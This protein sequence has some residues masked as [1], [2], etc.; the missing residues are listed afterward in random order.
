[1]HPR[2]TVVIPVFNGMPFLPEAVESILFQTYQDFLLL[3]IDDGSTDDSL[4]YLNSL[5]DPRIEIRQQRNLGLCHSLNG[6]IAVIKS[7]FVA[8][9]DQDDVALPS[10]LEEQMAFLVE[11]PNYTCVLSNISRIDANSREFGYYQNSSLGSVKDYHPKDYGSI[12]HSTICFRKDKFL[13]IGGYRQSVYPVDDFDLLLRF[14][15]KEKVA[16][17]DKPLVKYRIHSKAA[18]FK[19]FQD[20][21]MI[22]RYVTAMSQLRL[23]GKPEISLD[24]FRNTLDKSTLQQKLVRY[25]KQTGMLLFR[26]AGLLIGNGQ[27]I[28][29]I[30]SLLGAFLCNPQFVSKRL[31]TLRKG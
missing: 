16:V 9:L 6:A 13:E 29:G 14:W 18:T 3:I 2:L 31:L 26:K 11:H 8:R 5:S 4:Q 1:M 12:V 28:Q 19:V 25:F 22:T 7:E 15:E 23:D 27:V 20:M 24:E 10:R 21:Q 17:I 30:L